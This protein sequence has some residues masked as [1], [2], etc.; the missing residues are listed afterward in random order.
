MAAK[1]RNAGQT[2]VCAN[3]LYVHSSVLERF[4]QALIARV[5]ALKVGDGLVPGT[6]IGPLI[7][8]AAVAAQQALVADAVAAGARVAVGG[9]PLSS[10]GGGG[11]GGGCGGGGGNFFAPTVLTGLRLGDPRTMAAR[12]VCEEVFGPLAPVVAFDSEAQVVEAANSSAVGLAAYVYSASIPRALRLGGA[13][14]V[15]MVGVNTGLISAAQAPFGGVKES[16]FG[17]EGGRAGLLEYT[18][19]KYV[20]MGV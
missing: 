2:C 8:P 14:E 18:N 7:T 3:T 6:Q 17:R 4:T 9:A 5:R 16:G 11:G 19:T 10:S 13:L 20:M 12:V 1:F 15:G